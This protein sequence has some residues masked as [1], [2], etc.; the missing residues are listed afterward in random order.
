MFLLGGLSLPFD[1]EITTVMKRFVSTAVRKIYNLRS[2]KLRYVEA[3]WLE[4]K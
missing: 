4:V 2:D 3:P 1:S